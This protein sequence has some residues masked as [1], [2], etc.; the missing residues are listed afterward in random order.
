MIRIGVCII[1]FFFECMFTSDIFGAVEAT[2]AMGNSVN[3]SGNTIC[4]G[5]NSPELLWLGQAHLGDKM[6]P[7]SSWISGDAPIDYPW[8]ELGRN[9]R[10]LLFKA[11]PYLARVTILY[12]SADVIHFWCDYNNRVYEIATKDVKAVVKNVSGV[13]A[14]PVSIEEL[15]QTR[16]V[17]RIKTP[18]YPAIPRSV[19]KKAK[20]LNI[21]RI[22]QKDVEDDAAILPEEVDVENDEESEVLKEWK[23]NENNLVVFLLPGTI[24]LPYVTILNKKDKDLHFRYGWDNKV[25]SIGNEDLRSIEKSRSK[26]IYFR[27][28][29]AKLLG[30]RRI[31]IVEKENYPKFPERRSPVMGLTRNIRNMV[32]LEPVNFLVGSMGTLEYER[33][34][35][36]NFSI[37]VG[38]K[39]TFIDSRVMQ[40]RSGFDFGPTERHNAYGIEATFRIYPR[41]DTYA[42]VGL[43]IGPSFEYSEESFERFSAA[44]KYKKVALEMGRGFVFERN[45]GLAVSP[46]WGVG[47]SWAQGPIIRDMSDRLMAPLPILSEGIIVIFGCRIGF[48][49]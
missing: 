31:A 14:W 40:F 3:S 15:L 13:K 5:N 30:G 43:W 32:T 39:F 2:M 47:Y 35:T 10:H 6:A 9:Q 1:L 48:G 7:A 24:F 4:V 21:L 46:F 45:K 18:G 11:T 38:G 41:K 34:I 44:I 27:T 25:Y 26:D 42:P 12:Q 20:E 22:K 49:F 33:L 28:D 36:D 19:R 17:A 29:L 16:L 8:S 23:T 37:S